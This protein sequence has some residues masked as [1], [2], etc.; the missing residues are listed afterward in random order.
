[1]RKTLFLLLIGILLVSFV[2]VAG[3]ENS[4]QINDDSTRFF[5]NSGSQ[6][7]IQLTPQEPGDLPDEVETMAKVEPFYIKFDS[8]SF[9]I[10]V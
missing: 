2:G 3:S 5:L 4:F 8:S 10:N 9:S 6:E 7:V 1:M